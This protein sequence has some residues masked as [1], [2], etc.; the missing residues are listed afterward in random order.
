MKKIQI[1]PAWSFTDEA[2]NRLD[3]K[4]FGLLQAVHQSGKL[5]SAAAEAGIS[6][7]HAWNLL[8]KWA[9]FFGVELVEM[10][11]GRGA[12]LSPLGDKLLWAEQRVAAR[13]GP[14]LESLGSELNLEIQ[15]LLEGVKP[16]LRMHAS[17]GY[18]V[19]LLP[20]FADGFQLDLQYCSPQEALAALNRGGCDIAGFHMPTAAVSGPLTKG[21]RRLLKPRSHRIIR[22]ITRTQGLMVRPGNPKA[23]AS[24][25]DLARADVRFINRQ[26]DS[27]TRALLDGL[28]REAGVSSRRI[29][30]YE[31]EEFTHSAVAAYIA[32]GMADVGFGVEAAAHQFGLDFVPLATEHYL[33]VCHRQVLNDPKVQRLIETIE[34][35]AFRQAV[36]QLPGYSPSR[37]GE[38]CGVDEL[39]AEENA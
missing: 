12:R 14:Q 11:K 21:Y 34:G 31:L 23:I 6:Y 38:V 4:L 29:R 37:C 18:A 22:F 20:K 3:P 19:A 28:I 26:K 15:Q 2:G 33:M 5:T 17:H 39:F 16:V 7:R 13:L 1:E 25:A 32:A 27:G 9:D 30:G 24:L 8:N 36:S 35:E 10:Q